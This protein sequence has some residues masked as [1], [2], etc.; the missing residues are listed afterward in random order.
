MCHD[1]IAALKFSRDL[2]IRVP[3][4]HRVVE[5]DAEKHDYIIIME[6][7]HGHTLEELWPSIGWWRT[8]LLAKQLRSYL[9]IMHSITS[10]TAGGLSSGSVRSP[11]L[12]SLYAPAPHSSPAAFTGYLNWWLLSCRPYRFKARTDLAFEHMPN[13]IFIHQDLAPRNLIVD[14]HNNLWVVDWEYAGFY[15]PYMEYVN[16]DSS[17]MAWLNGSSWRARLAKWRWALLR[18][19]AAGP[20]WHHIKYWKGLAE[21]HRRSCI[22]RLDRT[23]YSEQI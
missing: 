3:V 19:I 13:H 21:I 2:G 9:Q 17:S 1:E 18:W 11:W 15:P 7:I 4:V 20:P 12:E 23:P 14:A 22:Y 10:M 6:R 16:I 8:L 5:V